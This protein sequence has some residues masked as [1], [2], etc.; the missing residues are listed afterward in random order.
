MH[1]ALLL[2][3]KS[4]S[5]KLQK[6]LLYVE[7]AR[8]LVWGDV[9]PS[10]MVLTVLCHLKLCAD[11]EAVFSTLFSA[12]SSP[13][14]SEERRQRSLLIISLFRELCI[15]EP[16]IDVAGF[17]VEQIQWPNRLHNW[18]RYMLANGNVIEA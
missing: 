14:E 11:K 16:A 10:W 8:R 18:A 2:Y 7:C 3:V 17:E 13:F 5:C 9:H 15:F 1:A 4:L 12:E 6:V